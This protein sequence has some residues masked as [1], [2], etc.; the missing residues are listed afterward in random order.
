MYFGP[1][2]KIPL[3]VSIFLSLNTSLAFPSAVR[4]RSTELLA[5][6]ASTCPQGSYS[7]VK[8]HRRGVSTNERLRDDG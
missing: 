7:T 4:L 1:A 8:L 5:E 2:T 3:W 6:G